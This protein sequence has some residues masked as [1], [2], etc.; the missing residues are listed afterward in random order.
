MGKIVLLVPREEMLYQAHNILQEKKYAISEMRVI[1]TENAVVEARNAIAAG[2]SIL[3]ARGLQASIIKQ[4]TDIPVVEIVVTAQEMALLVVK[5]KQIVGKDMPV[6]AVVGVK[7]MFCDMSY[8]ETI[9]DIR[10]RT[11]FASNG[12]GLKEQSELAIEEGADLV[13]GGDVAVGTAKAAGCPSLFLS[14]TEDSLRTAFAMAESMDFAMGAEKRSTAQMETLLDYSFN[15]VVNMDKDGVITAVNPVMKDILGPDGEQVAGRKMEEVFKD[16]DHGRLAEVLEGKLESHASFMQAGSTAVF[17][18]LAPVRVGDETEGAIL[19]CHKVRR[20]RQGGDR[21]GAMADGQLRHHG[22]IARGCFQSILQQS[23]AMQE[24]VHLARLYSQSELPVLI[25][26]ETG[27]EQRLLAES[28]HNAGLYNEGAFFSLSCSGLS[29]TEQHN[30]IFGDKGAVFLASQGTIY[31]EDLEQMSLSN[32]FGLYQLIRYKTGS[33]RDFARTVRFDIR[34]MASSSMDLEALWD[35]AGAGRF[36]KDLL[37]LISGLLLRVPPLHKRPE[38]MEYMAEALLK[39]CCDKY[40]RYHVLTRGALKCLMEYDWPGNR[41]QLETYMNRLVLTAEK[42]SID[43]IMVR[44][45]LGQLY[46][47]R[48]RTQDCNVPSGLSGPVMGEEERLIRQALG[49]F[50]GNRERT[51]QSLNI[52]K[53][54]LWRKMKKYNIDSFETEMK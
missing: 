24:C 25:L 8:F 16:I 1:Q 52:S 19:T 17:A 38:D 31:I 7:N 30:L 20:Q 10:L 37:Y 27:T 15:G 51:A 2:A 50:N 3:I 47:D 4:Y 14:M 28:M 46:P 11:Y 5:A 9:Y 36:R 18:I 48:G 49:R 42:R 13:I 21:Q 44:S 53:A 33:S 26:G 34:I 54:T 45:L 40:A 29:E 32:Q 22:L 39:E 43:E 35:L 12:A 6:I 23:K 41:L